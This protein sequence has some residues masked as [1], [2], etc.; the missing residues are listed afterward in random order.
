MDRARP[1]IH[2]S[3]PQAIELGIAMVALF[4]LDA[5]HEMAVPVRRPGIELAWAAVG[6]IAM[7]ELSA[8]DRPYRLRHGYL[9]SSI[10]FA[11]LGRYCSGLSNSV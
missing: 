3:K 2:P 7:G 11:A 8:F 4:D 6:A 9:L 5:N 1:G 10:F